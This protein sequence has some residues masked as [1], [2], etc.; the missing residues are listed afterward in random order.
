MKTPRETLLTQH[1]QA[2]PQL[3]RIRRDVVAGLAEPKASWSAGIRMW[4]TPNRL[5]WG[6]FA[7][8]WAFIFLLNFLAAEITPESPRMLATQTP[9]NNEAVRERQKLYAELMGTAAE[10]K[11]R[12][13]APRPHSARR[14]ETIFA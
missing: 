1:R 9:V 13:S 6:G 14:P 10:T 5:A 8:A 12:Q 4:L 7:A 3:D 11:E 2:Q